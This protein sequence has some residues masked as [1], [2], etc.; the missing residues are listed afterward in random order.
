[1]HSILEY[2]SNAKNIL[3][4]IA[5]IDNLDARRAE[6]VNSKLFSLYEQ[7]NL[8]C[9]KYEGNL[10]RTRNIIAN[11]NKITFIMKKSSE[12]LGWDIVYSDIRNFRKTQK[13]RH[14]VVSASMEAQTLPKQK[15][16]KE[17]T[18]EITVALFDVKRGE[19]TGK[20]EAIQRLGGEFAPSKE[21]ME[22]IE[23]NKDAINKY[24]GKYYEYEHY[25]NG[26]DS[27]WYKTKR[28]KLLNDMNTILEKLGEK[29]KFFYRACGSDEYLDYITK[30]GMVV[31]GH[32]RHT[33]D[34]S[35]RPFLVEIE[36]RNAP[37]TLVI[38][39][40]KLNVTIFPVI[41]CQEG[42]DDNYDSDHKML[43]TPYGNIKFTY[44]TEEAGKYYPGKYGDEMEFR[45]RPFPKNAIK[46]V[47]VNYTRS[48][49]EDTKKEVSELQ[50]KY[51][52]L[53]FK[54]NPRSFDFWL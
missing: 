41:Y 12:T 36:W 35:I 16:Q 6:A 3:K 32:G 45:A 47:W 50:K 20:L 19:G 49:L 31:G 10:K 27:R 8:L 13:T 2:E 24:L 17:N 30:E 33:V 25:D 22:E 54:I 29:S 1:V 4:E 51:P 34:M 39:K 5:S 28:Q 26:S 7:A 43:K 52:D 38:N 21:V 53:V 46:E 18:S 23:R 37:F 44:E 11:I 14:S 15:Q 48:N 40:E 42:Y 9:E